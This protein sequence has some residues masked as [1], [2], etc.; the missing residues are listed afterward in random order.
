MDRVTFQYLFNCHV[1]DIGLKEVENVK[2]QWQLK[3]MVCF[4]FEKLI[5]I[6]S[7]PYWV[8]HS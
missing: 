8:P 1:E 6:K 2:L 7:L 3:K 4:K 5:S